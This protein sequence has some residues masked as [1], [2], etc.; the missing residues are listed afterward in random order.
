MIGHG[1]FARVYAAADTIEGIKV[2]LKI[3]FEQWVDDDLLDQFKQ[4]IRLTAQLN[5]PN[6]LPLK[7]ADLIDHRL[8]VATP[9][10]VE[11]LGHR[12]E[13]RISVAKAYAYFEQMIAAVAYAH[14]R[15][16]IH[17]DIKPENF[18]I[19]EEDLIRLAD[20]GIAKVSQ[21]TI[22]GSGTGTVGHMSVEQAM[23]KPSLRSDV[24]SL[25]LIM[26][27][28]LTSHWPEF[29]FTW[30]PPGAAKLR[31]KRVHPEMI[32]L[33]KKAIEPNARR[34]FADAT[35]LEL[36]FEAAYPKALRNLSR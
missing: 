6:I 31:T 35:H 33:V 10:G 9:L 28:M 18:I 36:A 24:F 8:I 5:H 1:G 23:G 15:G 4:E 7:N 13:R 19:F 11:T 25:G 2:A 34:R 14:E 3:P 27:R 16:I 20:F 26:Y 32:R 22:A 29:P 17:C 12:L 30:P 21:M